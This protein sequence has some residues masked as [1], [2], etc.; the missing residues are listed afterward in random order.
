MDVTVIVILAWFGACVGSF[1]NVVA[2]RVPLAISVASPPSACPVCG[3]GIAWFDNVPMVS[4]FLLR[5]RC[6]ACGDS[7]SPRYPIVEAI[8]ALSWA[9]AT[10]RV[11]VSWALPA[12]LL[13]ISALL[14]LSVIDIDTLRVPDVILLPSLAAT[15]VL[16]VGACAI[17]GGVGQ[18][19]GALLGAVVGFS[20]LALVHLISPRGLGFGD[21]KLA[22]L[23]GLLLGW[24]GWWAVVAG[25]YGA[26]VLGAVV[27]VAI[28]L[29][30]SR[31]RRRH[32]P[33]APFLAVATTL[34]VLVCA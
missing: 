19:V 24:Q 7:I 31:D 1:L 15:S 26:F 3:V 30:T 16:L 11:G 32:I 33:F 13:A 12:V 10:W 6:R 25:L 29:L 18:A 21:V 20:S 34:T 22:A 23:C 28:L 9:L 8:A 17:D 2:W 5:G 14:V 27:G 4:W